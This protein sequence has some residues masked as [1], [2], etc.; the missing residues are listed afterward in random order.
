VKYAEIEIDLDKKTMKLL[1]KQ[2]KEAGIPMERYAA[3]I[4]TLYVH[5]MK[6]STYRNFVNEVADM[7]CGD[8]DEWIE[9]QEKLEHVIQ[10]AREIRGDDG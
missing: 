7:E 1:K 9:L 3:D 2:A 5:D 6:L 4:I 8:G 10:E